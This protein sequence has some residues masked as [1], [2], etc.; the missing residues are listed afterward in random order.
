M[1]KCLNCDRE[2]SRKCDLT[3]HINCK[4]CIPK[5]CEVCGELTTNPKFCSSKCFGTTSRGRRH[6]EETKIKISIS[7]G[8]TGE[9]NTILNNKCLACDKHLE[10]FGK[11]CDNNCHQEFQYIEFLRK[12]K[13]GEDDGVRS[14]GGT[15]AYIKRWLIETYGEKC[16]KCGWCE[17]HPKSGR[18]PIELHHRDGNY[19]NNSKENVCLLCPNCHSLTDCFRALNYGNE[20]IKKES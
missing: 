1:F 6:S 16:S 4:T 20:R 8:G 14:S 17:K 10:R 5:P 13:S 19:K 9:V 7:N 18:I 15:S 12:W 11:F 3:R 2:F